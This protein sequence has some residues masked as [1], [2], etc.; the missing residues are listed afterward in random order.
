MYYTDVGSVEEKD[1]IQQQ[2]GNAN[3][4][5]VVASN[6]FGLGIDQLDVRVVIHV[7]PIH[8]LRDYGQESGRGGRDGQRSEAIIIVR[9][10]RQEALQKQAHSRQR[11]MRCR[12]IPT[13][14]RD[15]FGQEKVD[16]FISGERCWWIYLD[17]EMD[18]RFNY[19]Q[20]EDGEEKCNVCQK[21]EQAIEE[22]ETMQN[23][24]IAEQE[25][26]AMY[27][28][29]RMLDSGINMPSSS[30]GM[31]ASD[32][33]TTPSSSIELPD[34]SQ[35]ANHKDTLRN[36]LQ[37]SPISSIISSNL[38]FTANLI[39]IANQYK[40]EAQQVEREQQRRRIQRQN[41][42]EGHEVQ[43][44]EQQLEEWSRRCPLCF[45]RGHQDN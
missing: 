10:G 29:D 23:A 36:T 9:A 20:C 40:F 6:A 45:I 33:T 14:D 12:V 38:G 39:T 11:T 15:Q 41:Q 5:V 19:V 37:K 8:Q 17:Q 18:G 25:R 21:D 16:E 32:K 35:L 27:K 34:M 7:G 3:G 43:E 1:Q 22:A 42:Q 13:A 4:R 31:Q 2:Q 28:Q 26:Q 44:L 24:Y 30:F